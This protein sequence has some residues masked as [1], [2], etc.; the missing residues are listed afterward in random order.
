MTGEKGEASKKTEDA[1]D[2]NSPYYIHASDY[3]KQMQVNEV[4]NDNNFNEWKQEMINF[5][6]AKNKIGLVD[7]SIKKPESTS[8]MYMAWM[9]ADAMIKGWLTTAMEKSIRTS[10]RYANTSAEIWKDLEERFEKEGAP[11]AY[12]LKQSLG[13][14]RQEGAS[15][16]SYY[17]KLRSIWDELQLVLP[18]PRC[19]C[20]GCECALG[21]RFN[22]LKEKERIYEFL[23]G[24]DEDFS[25]IRTQILAM[26]PAPSLGATYHLVAEDE[27]QRAISGGSRRA[28]GDAAAFQ[29]NLMD[30]KAPWQTQG[31]VQTANKGAQRVSRQGNEKTEKCIF[32][33]KE[34]HV[35][36]GC[37]KRI[38]Y[39]DWWP[40]KKDKS[41]PKAACVEIGPSP[42][43]GLN[44][45]QYRLF[46]EHFKEDGIK[47]PN[48]KANLAE[49]D[50]EGLDWCG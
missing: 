49:I 36:D 12:E 38:G 10:V 15:V 14:T 32:C 30:R 41:K 50:N 22:D 34:G 42:V 31:T 7:G 35:K 5:L 18:M 17:T 4:L 21:K 20:N 47:E 44:D 46:V 23:M 19:T 45:E 6:F 43:P 25:I 39:P 29:V 28:T 13:N 3:P 26:K 27:Q 8:P 11:R 40:G 16:S 37:F 33:G 48:P 9:R 24:L 2:T 1:I